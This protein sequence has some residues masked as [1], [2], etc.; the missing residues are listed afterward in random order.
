[1]KCIICDSNLSG[2]QKK[3]CSNYCKSKNHYGN[4]RSA[5]K[6]RG[7]NRKKYFVNL[8]GGKC[9]KCSY[10]TCLDALCFHHMKDKSFTLDAAN[11]RSKSL[12]K[13][14]Q[15]IK[16]CI[17]LCSN[18]HMEDHHPDLYIDCIADT[19]NKQKQKAI[20]RKILLIESKG[21]KCSMC[22]YRANLSALC[23]H[24]VNPKTKKIKLDFRGLANYSLASIEAEL[25]KCQLLCS[26]CHLEVHSNEL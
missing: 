16:K 22:S 2:L 11:L 26:N 4:N 15:E 5:Q 13:L 23:F 14:N 20:S 18:C 19:N 8:L 21:G 12:T 1:V 3:Y 10:S 7:K 17:L 25:E 24:H 6:L 9:S